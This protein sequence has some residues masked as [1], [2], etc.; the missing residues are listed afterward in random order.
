MSRQLLP[1]LDAAAGAARSVKNSRAAVIA[2]HLE[3]LARADLH[4]LPAL[5]RMGE[6][7]S[8][9]TQTPSTA[10]RRPDRLAE[11]LIVLLVLVGVAFAEVGDL[12]GRTAVAANTTCR[13][14]GAS[15]NAGWCAP[16]VTPGATLWGVGSAGLACDL[17]CPA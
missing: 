2:L 4:H 3:H 17:A 12:P 7:R 14:A 1:A 6:A 13:E 8:V 9:D 5:H 15:R 11:L 10:S 16:S